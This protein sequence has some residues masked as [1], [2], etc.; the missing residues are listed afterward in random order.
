MQSTLSSTLLLWVAPDQLQPLA[1]QSST[2]SAIERLGKV[3][4]EGLD[5]S[6][7]F[8]ATEVAYK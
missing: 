8:Q 6:D 3:E 7:S 2:T 5:V 1:N 4:K